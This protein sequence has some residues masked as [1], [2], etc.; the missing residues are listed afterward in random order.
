M[1]IAI[2]EPIQI[3]SN[4]NIGTQ[5]S[6]HPKEIEAPNGLNICIRG[7]KGNS[8]EDIPSQVLIE[9]HEG[10]LKVHVWDGNSKDHYVIGIDPE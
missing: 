5:I 7:F 9:V 3:D 10:K 1:N 4:S 8:S 2:K 6:A